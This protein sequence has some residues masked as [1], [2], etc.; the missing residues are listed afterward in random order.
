VITS[1][2]TT[3]CSK[4]MKGFKHIEVSKFMFVLVLFMNVDAGH[5][6][7]KVMRRFQIK[8]QVPSSM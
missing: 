8:V 6:I 1:D 3:R 4:G 7:K 5:F 2:E